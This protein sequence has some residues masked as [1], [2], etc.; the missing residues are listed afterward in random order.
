MDA[1]ILVFT[2]AI[3][4][5][6][7]VPVA[8]AVGLSAI[9]GAFWIDLP[10]E[11]VMIQITSGVNKFSLLAIPFFIL[12]GAIMAEGGIARRLV[13]FAYIFVG[14]IRGGLSLV[15]IVASTFFGAISGSSVADT[16][17]IGSVMIPEMDKKGYPRDFA[18]AVTA[19]G[20]VQA[21]L[22][23]PS[24]NSVIYSL[25]TGGTVSIAAL[26]IAGILPG[27]LLSFTLMLMCVGF[28]YKRGYPKGERVPFRQALKIFVDTLWGLMTVV[29]IMGGILSGIFTA[30]ESAAIACLWSFFVTMFI[31]RDYK[32]SEL[33]KLMYRTVKTVTIVMILI[34]FAAS[35]GAIMTYM[36]LPERIT[37]FFTSVSDNKYVILMCIN[38]MLLLIGTLMDMAPLIL[39]L[40]PV[41]MPVT[42]SLGIDPVH[43]GMIML[44]NLGIGLITPPVG[45]VLF[46]ASAVSKQKIEQV[47][48]AM[49]PFYGA[50]LLVL[51]LVTY[52]PEISLWLPRVFGVYTG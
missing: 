43:F 6:I 28:A 18:A 39:I 27:L 19:S 8:Y 42:H 41:L 16:A 20:S 36:Q 7:G 50:L 45:S 46:V 2:L 32:W 44:I 30:T 33:P 12:A 29:I 49:L 35:F 22:T 21:I 52:I 26:F 34:G 9:A 31:Y 47:V 14:F 25:A 10:L 1:F 15:N 3:L 4:L 37:E 51:M 23:P 38:I 11:A 17:S 48:K 13:S 40:T 5:A 24:H